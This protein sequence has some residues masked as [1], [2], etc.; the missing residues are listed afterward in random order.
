M[1]TAWRVWF[2]NRFYAKAKFS[3]NPKQEGVF[4]RMSKVLE[5]FSFER[6]HTVATGG[7]SPG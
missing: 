5:K 4:G 1:Q 6:Y 3:T 2:L 7:Y